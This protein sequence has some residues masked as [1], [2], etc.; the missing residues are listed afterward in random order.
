MKGGVG[1]L[2]KMCSVMVSKIQIAGG[3]VEALEKKIFSK[4]AV[5]EMRL[6]NYVLN[7]VHVRFI[8]AGH[9]RATGLVRGFCKVFFFFFFYRF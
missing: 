2:Q 8:Y 5:G 4:W 3:G 1:G 9:K 7:D 6:R